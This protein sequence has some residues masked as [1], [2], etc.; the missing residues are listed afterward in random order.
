MPFFSIIL[1]TFNRSKQLRNANKSVLEQ[2]YEDFDVTMVPLMIP[3][4]FYNLLTI[5]RSFMIWRLI[6]AGRPC[7]ETMK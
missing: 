7:H 5:H 4:R 2:T 1:T 6:V 3:L